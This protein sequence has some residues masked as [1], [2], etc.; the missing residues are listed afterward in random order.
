[1]IQL[2]RISGYVNLLILKISEELQTIALHGGDGGEAK[3][4]LSQ[5]LP[6]S[7]THNTKSITNI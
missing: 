6:F 2:I 1:M 5:K 3:E 7:A 4:S